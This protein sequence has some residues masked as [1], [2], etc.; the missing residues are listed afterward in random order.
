MKKLRDSVLNTTIAVKIEFFDRFS[1][2]T[3][4][5]LAVPPDRTGVFPP[6][7]L[8]PNPITKALAEL[9]FQWNE[10]RKE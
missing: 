10:V 6:E 4:I 3:P 9:G 2:E 8:A 1:I 7:A 5:R